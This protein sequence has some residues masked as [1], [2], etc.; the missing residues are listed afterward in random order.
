MALQTQLLRWRFSVPFSRAFAL[1]ALLTLLGV[2]GFAATAAAQTERTERLKL[3]GRAQTVHLYLPRSTPKAIAVLSSGDLGWMGFVVDLAGFLQAHDVAVLGFNTRAYL[4]SFTGDHKALDPADIPG[5]YDVLA[6]EAQRLLGGSHRPV[7]IG[8]SEG[9]GL[10]VV[11]AS[12][13]TRSQYQGIVGLGTPET[14]ELGWSTWKDWTIWITKGNPKQPHLTI[15]PH[16]GR[17]APTPLIFVQSTH[18]EFVPSE[19]TARLFN[20]AREPKRLVSID[21]NNH[22]FS[23]RRR[24][25]QAALLE[26]MAWFESHTP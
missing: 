6:R 11:A 9:A 12:S 15:T 22:R 1:V 5:H 24:E 23:N 18:D 25:L 8:V 16:V 21:A 10:S 2:V 14:I 13:E 20:A 17:V 4:A 26:A 7:L 3:S 19:E